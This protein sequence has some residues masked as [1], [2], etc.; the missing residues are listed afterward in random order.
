MI[1]EN[2]FDFFAASKK[3]AAVDF[4]YVG[5]SVAGTDDTRIRFSLFYGLKSE[6]VFKL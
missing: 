2:D 4:R 1:K 6:H 3:D 5:E